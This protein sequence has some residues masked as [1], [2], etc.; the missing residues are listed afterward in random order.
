LGF[1]HASLYGANYLLA[2]IFGVGSHPLMIAYGSIFML[3][4]VERACDLRIMLLSCTR[5]NR[6]IQR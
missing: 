2:E 6:K 3:A 5:L 4:A 1:R